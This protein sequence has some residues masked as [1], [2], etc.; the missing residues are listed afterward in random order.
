MRVRKVSVVAEELLSRKA[1]GK[2]GCFKVQG[3]GVSSDFVYN[4]DGIHTYAV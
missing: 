1:L 2:S 4:L 3:G